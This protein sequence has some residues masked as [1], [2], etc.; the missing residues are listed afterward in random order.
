[1]IIFGVLLSLSSEF[2]LIES[3]L[4]AYLNLCYS[5]LTKT[6]H[7]RSKKFQ[8]FNM[9]RYGIRLQLETII[10]STTLSISNSLFERRLVASAFYALDGKFPG[11]GTPGLSNPPGWGRKRGQI[12]PPSSANTAQS[13]TVLPF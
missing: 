11:M 13:S 10:T 5:L 6:Q 1:M 4:A 2:G 12:K 7:Q 8:K 9:Y 3:L